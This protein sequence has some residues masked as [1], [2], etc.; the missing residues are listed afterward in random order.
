MTYHV[1][2]ETSQLV[3]AAASEMR[4][5]STIAATRSATPE[6][7]D[8]LEVAAQRLSIQAREIRIHARAIRAEGRRVERE[9]ARAA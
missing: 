9:R 6:A 3:A 5:I 2:P 8:K 7:L 4:A 1:P